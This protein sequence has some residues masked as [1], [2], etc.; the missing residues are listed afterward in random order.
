MKEEH[1]LLL[2]GIWKFINQVVLIDYIIIIQGGDFVW[3]I[4]VE[5]TVWRDLHIK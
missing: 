4:M 2:S 3:V 1:L 5:F